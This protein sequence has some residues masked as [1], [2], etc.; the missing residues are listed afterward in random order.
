ML[1]SGSMMSIGT[2]EASVHSGEVWKPHFGSAVPEITKRLRWSFGVGPYSR[3]KSNGS[4]G[5]LPNGIW[6]SLA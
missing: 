2:L 4:I 5:P 6:S 1:L 3:C